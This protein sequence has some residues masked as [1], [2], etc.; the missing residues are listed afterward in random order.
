MNGIDWGLPPW[1]L[2]IFGAL[3]G[4][5]IGSFLNVVI[6]RLPLDES[7]VW[8]GSRCPECGAGISPRD[9]I[10]IISFILLLGR[11]RA[12]RSRISL[13]YPAVEALTAIVFALILVRDGVSLLTAAELLIGSMLIALMAIDA[14]HQLLPDR[15]TYPLL[16][17][18]IIGAGLRGASAVSDLDPYVSLTITELEFSPHRAA[19]L[20]AAILAGAIPAL[21][22]L[23]FVDLVL[24][25]KYLDREQTSS[26]ASGEMIPAEAGPAAPE[27]AKEEAKEEQEYR[28][29]RR[30]LRTTAIAGVV[31][32][33]IWAAAVEAVGPGDPERWLAIYDG[34]TGAALGATVAVIPIWL[35]RASYFYLRG[36]EGLGLGDIKLMAAVGAFFGWAGA[37]ATLMLGSLGGIVLGLVLARRSGRGLQTSLP[38]GVCLGGA[39]LLLLVAGSSFLRVY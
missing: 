34:L 17:A 21:W 39:A 15:L 13:V 8:P 6:H 18:A 25:N 23:D 5:T 22:L 33:I 14:R 32:A 36:V 2:A 29:Y 12:C 19:L 31:L 20:G 11:C 37:I 27:E 3:V 26:T 24:F 9:N 7:V 4:L 35:L 38:L 30:L 16:L 28:R 1:F 10:P